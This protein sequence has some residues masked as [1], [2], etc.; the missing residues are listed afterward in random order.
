MGRR[1][2][3]A[4]WG[5]ETSSI[6]LT[7]IGV[8]EA[9]IRTAVR[10][11]F[12]GENP[13]P[14]YA[15]ANAAREIVSTIGNQVGVETMEQQIAAFMGVQL[16][17]M[18][19]PWVR[20]ANFLKHADRDARTKFVVY[21]ESVIYILYLACANFDVVAN[22]LPVEARTFMVWDHARVPKV[23]EMPL[24]LQEHY[25]HCIELFPGI[26]RA[27]DLAEQKKIG[28][29]VLKT[30]LANPMLQEQFSRVQRTGI[31]RRRTDDQGS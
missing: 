15:L 13:A 22:G 23:S 28:L 6:E 27:I 20:Q 29:A 11:F 1:S 9:H 7:K 31:Y 21:E 8:A 5:T 14:V 18:L 2:H 3:T 16:K 19:Y 10:L 12:E 26:R 17:E 4:R 24:S 30:A 25:R